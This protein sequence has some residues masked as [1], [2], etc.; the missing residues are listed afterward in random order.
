MAK[1]VTGRLVQMCSL[2]PDG[3]NFHPVSTK[4]DQTCKLTDRLN[5][6]IKSA[7]DDE[8]KWWNTAPPP[9]F[10]DTTSIDD[11]KENRAPGI[12]VQIPDDILEQMAALELP[13]PGSLRALS[14]ALD[15]L[16]KETHS[17]TLAALK[18]FSCR[19]CW[20]RLIGVSSQ[21][22]SQSQTL[23]PPCPQIELDG[24]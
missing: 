14:C 10:D 4:R 24:T 6:F 19:C 2:C 18:T 15:N 7:D 1:E 17:F 22:Q 20:E 12:G 9:D 13:Q 11:N 21:I 8:K 16:D 23:G 5:H 3:R